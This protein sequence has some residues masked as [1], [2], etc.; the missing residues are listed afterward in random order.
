MCLRPNVEGKL[1]GRRPSD[2]CAGALIP[3]DFTRGRLAYPLLG[4]LFPNA[5]VGVQGGG[6]MRQAT[7]IIVCAVYPCDVVRDVRGNRSVPRLAAYAL[8]RGQA[9]GAS[10]F[11]SLR[12]DVARR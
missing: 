12:H 11:Q 3:R 4:A 6:M 5:C 9:L 2:N 8:E 1:L 7:D 10:L